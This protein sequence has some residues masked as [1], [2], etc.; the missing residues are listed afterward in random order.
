MRWE[1]SKGQE[2]F[3][4]FSGHPYRFSLRRPVFDLHIC[5]LEPVFRLSS[6]GTAQ[7]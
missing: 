3:A 5:V 2:I 7:I 1:F 4:V 6:T